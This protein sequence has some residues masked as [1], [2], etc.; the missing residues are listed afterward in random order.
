MLTLEMSEWLGAPIT[1]ARRPSRLPVVDPMEDD[2]GDMVAVGVLVKM[3]GFGSP[4]DGPRL[5]RQLA[6]RCLL[7]GWV[8][9]GETDVDLPVDEAPLLAGPEASHELVERTGMLRSELEPGEEV[10]W[11]VQVAAVVQS[12]RDRGEV[13]QADVDVMGP[14]LEDVSA[15]VLGEVPPCR[16]RPDRDKGRARGLGSTVRG[17]PRS[18]RCW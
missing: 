5:D 13:A 6:S 8:G 7:L 10:E 15:L 14:L 16:R 3:A 18:A 2:A 9:S 11:L 17:A 12:P 4:A 1:G